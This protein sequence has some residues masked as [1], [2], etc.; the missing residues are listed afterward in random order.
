MMKLRDNNGK[1]C[2]TP[3]AD[4]PSLRRKK[5]ANS[6][7]TSSTPESESPKV[8]CPKIDDPSPHRTDEQEKHRVVTG[9]VQTKSEAACST[10]PVNSNQIGEVETATV[11]PVMREHTENTDG[12]SSEEEKPTKKDLNH[13]HERTNQG[14]LMMT[15]VKEQVNEVSSTSELALCENSSPYA[16]RRSSYDDDEAS[17]ENVDL[18]SFALNAELQQRMDNEEEW[19]TFDPFYFIK[20][21]P[22]LT[23][24]QLCRQPVLPLKTRSSPEYSLVLDLDETLVHCS[25]TEMEDA[26]MTFQVVF[27]EV[28]YQ[29]FV[30]TRPKYKEFLERMSKLYEIILFTASKKVYADKLVNL[31][32]V[33]KQ[34]IR[35][36]LFREHCLCVQGNY[37]KDLTILG[38][39]LSKTV[40]I[41]NSP[42]AFAYQLS[43]GIPIESWFSDQDD[44]ELLK[45]IPFLEDLANQDND[46]RPLLKQ[47]FRIHELL[48]PH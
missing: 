44:T 39:D 40:I 15:Q 8:K 23:K 34:F 48:P 3:V 10:G 1:L 38:R 6:N 12:I 22:P 33:R 16:L 14:E 5:S 46:V 24:E 37:I 7:S 47:K 27:Q 41:D 32:D 45:L 28:V 11:A 25:L 18:Y 19:E 2:E 17:I 21:L 29:V 4:K 36:R 30:R 35:H 43:N 9:E 26:D 42:Q 13:N 31:L 20:H